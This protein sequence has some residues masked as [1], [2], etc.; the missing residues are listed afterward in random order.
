MKKLEFQTIEFQTIGFQTIEFQKLDQKID[1]SVKRYL[2]IN[3]SGKTIQM[4]LWWKLTQ[5]NWMKIE[6]EM[7]R[8][9]SHIVRHGIQD[10]K[11][12][13]LD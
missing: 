5:V 11:Y 4:P 3:Q 13:S 7:K 10:Y 9:Q 2:W 6:T 8:R 1:C 12:N